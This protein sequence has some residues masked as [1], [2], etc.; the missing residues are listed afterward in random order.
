MVRKLF[1][2]PHKIIIILAVCLV[3]ILFLTF[4]GWKKVSI[5]NTRPNSNTQLPPTPTVSIPLIST[6]IMESQNDLAQRYYDLDLTPKE[7]V[8]LFYDLMSPLGAFDPF[9]QNLESVPVKDITN[10]LYGAYGKKFGLDEQTV[11]N[12]PKIATSFGTDS[13]DPKIEFTP[14]MDKY[15]SIS[16]QMESN[17]EIKL[18]GSWVISV[19]RVNNYFGDIK[20]NFIWEINSNN[21]SP[22]FT[23]S[24]VQDV[25]KDFAGSKERLALQTKYKKLYK[26]TVDLSIHT[27]YFCNGKTIIIIGGTANNAIG[28]IHN[29]TSKDD[30][31]CGLLHDRF[32]IIKFIQIAPNWNYW[33][34]N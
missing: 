16:K 4:F 18:I 30:V 13:Y 17:D 10:F 25:T 21:E 24:P 20:R 8:A 32:R 14:N 28:Y 7:K 5:F 1:D 3:M 11:L 31:N 2:I 9:A 15:E 6:K 22:F 34:G 29:A 27:A 19:Y 26:E 33:V 12:L 23:Y